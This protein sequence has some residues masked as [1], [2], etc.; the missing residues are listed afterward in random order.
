[1]NLLKV[2][3]SKISFMVNEKHEYVFNKYSEKN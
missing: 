1:M 3:K 2:L